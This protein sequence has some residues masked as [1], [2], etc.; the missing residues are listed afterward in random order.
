[1]LRNCYF[2]RALLTVLLLLVM[3]SPS[4]AARDF[5]KPVDFQPLY[6]SGVK[7]EAVAADQLRNGLSVTFFLEY[8]ERS[9]EAL[10]NN[11]TVSFIVKEGQPVSQLNHQFGSEMVFDSGTNRGVAMR[12]KGYILFEQNGE[13]QLQ[14][15]SNDGVSVK[16]D[17]QA[18]ISDPEQHSDRLSNVG[19]VTIEKPGYYPT[20][21]DYFQRKGTASLKLFWKTPG[22]SQFV[23]IPANAY[24]HL[25]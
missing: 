2:R 22:S 3:N 19:H 14:A 13:Y 15:L 6:V 1:M 12:M 10:S 16:V 20:V 17:G 9:L 7:P 8:F 23:V 5:S 4:W 24:A 21:V 25:E 18:V 11:N